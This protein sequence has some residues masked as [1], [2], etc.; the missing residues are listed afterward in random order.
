MYVCMYIDVCMYMNA[1]MYMY[2]LHACICMLS[3]SIFVF[4]V[5]IEDKSGQLPGV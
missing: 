4:Q 1:C 2:A 5:V 3:Q